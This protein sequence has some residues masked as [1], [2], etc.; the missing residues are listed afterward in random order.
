MKS[1]IEKIANAILYE[2]YLL[3]PYRKSALKNQQRFNFGLLQPNDF[4]QTQVL[5]LGKAEGFSVRVRFLQTLT[6]QII[7]KDGIKQA[8]LEIDKQIFETWDEVVERNIETD[9]LI[10]FNF[11]CEMSEEYLSVGKAKFVRTT[12]EIYGRIEIET[13]NSRKNLQR[14]TVKIYNLSK[15]ERFI[16]T[17]AILSVENVE[18]V[19]LLEY[20]KEFQGE[21]KALKQNGLFPVLVEKNV[22]LASPIILYDFPQIAPES[23]G[24]ETTCFALAV[25]LELR[26]NTSLSL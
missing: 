23:S 9:K 17:H 8:R 1:K 7:D 11:D 13:Q 15:I 3:Y 18:F 10:E 21:V 12:E 2:G 26:E 19:S 4:F 25:A 20:E 16:S 22:M 14:L 6:R 24:E 5:V